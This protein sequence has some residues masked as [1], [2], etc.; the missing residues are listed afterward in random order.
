MRSVWKD[1]TC[2]DGVCDYPFEYKGYAH[3]GCISDC[4]RELNLMAVVVVLT[5]NFEKSPQGLQ[6]G[7]NLKELVRW[8]LCVA[9]Q[10]RSD[11]GLSDVCWYAPDALRFGV[12]AATRGAKGLRSGVWIRD[13]ACSASCGRRTPP[14]EVVSD[15]SRSVVE[16]GRV[17]PLLARCKDWIL[18]PPTGSR[19]T[20][21]RMETTQV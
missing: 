18:R 13:G 1:Q 16:C 2:G 4:G 10:A 5:G 19:V 14:P 7:P 21:C 12:R 9:S 3:L 20:Y 15:V 11:A 8:N 17:L 6:A